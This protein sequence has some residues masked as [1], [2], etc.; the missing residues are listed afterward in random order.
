MLY[1][2]R[3]QMRLFHFELFVL[4]L[5]KQQGL[6]A[7]EDVHRKLEIVSLQFRHEVVFVLQ[8]FV[9]VFCLVRLEIELLHLLD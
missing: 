7:L 9:D 8:V 5:L 2:K 3:I 1:I 4:L 6:L